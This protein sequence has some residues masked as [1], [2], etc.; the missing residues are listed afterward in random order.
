MREKRIAFKG[1][2]A[3]RRSEIDKVDFFQEVSKV[4][5]N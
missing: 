5:K 4:Q 1:T 3:S 2:P